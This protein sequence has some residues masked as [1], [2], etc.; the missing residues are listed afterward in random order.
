MKNAKTTLD[1]PGSRGIRLPILAV[2][3]CA[4]LCGLP[5]LAEHETP[6]CPP[7]ACGPIDPLDPS[8]TNRLTL[9]PGTTSAVHDNF[10]GDDAFECGVIRVTNVPFPDHWVNTGSALFSGTVELV[11]PDP[12]QS[13]PGKLKISNAVILSTGGPAG[14]EENFESSLIPLACGAFYLP[15]PSGTAGL[16]VGISGTLEVE[17]A[18]DS[19]EV[20]GNEELNLIAVARD[21][22][23]IFPVPAPA[24]SAL[25]VEVQGP[26][27]PAPSPYPVSS[28]A[29]ALG[30]YAAGE[31]IIGL[32][33]GVVLPAGESIHLPNSI[34]ATFGDMSPPGVPSGIGGTAPM[35]VAKLDPHGATLSLSWDTATCEGESMG[36][37]LIHGREFPTLLGEAYSPT[38][39]VCDIGPLESPF[40]WNDTPTTE[41]DTRLLWWLVLANDG[42]ETEGAWGPDWTGVERNGPGPN[43]SSHECGMETKS[44]ANTC[45]Q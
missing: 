5:A 3:L 36:H 26:G 24:P 41:G 20:Q 40:T 39:A 9:F 19:A 14:T 15:S 6:G 31:N 34:F 33:M 11:A 28:I 2:L 8:S 32:K 4:A 27:S 23:T 17:S 18:D 29:S 25:F 21:F 16:Q 7:S 10:P 22:T 35:T 1:S 38:G 12:S 42:A 45:G 13:L 37:M 44:L 43:G 30:S